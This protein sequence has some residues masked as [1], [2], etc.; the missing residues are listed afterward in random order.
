LNAQRDVAEVGEAI[1]AV[2]I[3]TSSR[4]SPLDMAMAVLTPQS[5]ARW[6]EP[7]SDLRLSHP[8]YLIIQQVK[9]CCKPACPSIDRSR[10]GVVAT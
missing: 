3:S 4:R 9:K 1:L 6:Q 5:K 2:P 10:E 7:L 8:D